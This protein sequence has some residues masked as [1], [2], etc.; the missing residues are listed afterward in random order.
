MGV[1]E[2]AFVELLSKANSCQEV[3]EMLGDEYKLGFH[4]AAKMAQ[5]GIKSKMFAV[6]DLEDSII[7]KTM[8]EPFKSIQKALDD[9]VIIIKKRGVKPRIIIMPLGS[10]TVPIIS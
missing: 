8:M 2:E 6:T 4:K 1:G 9:S 10:L 3:F 7:K 5:I